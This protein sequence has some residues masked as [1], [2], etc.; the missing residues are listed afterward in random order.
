MAKYI[1]VDIDGCLLPNDGE[2]YEDYFTGMPLFAK[3]VKEANE[4]KRS[5]IGFCTGRDRNYVEAVAFTSGRPNSWS[6]IESGIALFNPT[7]KQL[8]LNPKLAKEIREAF[9]TIRQERL[10]KILNEFRQLFDYPGK[11]NNI[12]LELRYGATIS[13]KECYEAVKSGLCDL[14]KEGV[15]TIRHSNLA[16]DISPAGIDKAAGIEFLA[17]LLC[18][19]ISQMGG[20]GDSY[21]DFP[22]LE[23]V[24]Y[25][26]CPA[27]AS[28]ECRQLVISRGG[29]PSKREY[30]SG[31]MDVIN[32]FDSIEIA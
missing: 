17:E 9:I 20:I 25:T 3:R 19:N 32:H 4:G 16:V 6:I 28:E 24:G 5:L 10:P 31:V 22:M 2:I 14:E 23:K 18:I 1:M 21:G 15:I 27:N 26:G 29:F 12:A 11:M 30:A 7:T 8:L 13:I